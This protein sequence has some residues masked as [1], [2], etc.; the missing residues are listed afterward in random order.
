MINK[1][2]PCTKEISMTK[3]FVNGACHRIVMLGHQVHGALA[4]Q[5][6]HDMHLYIKQAKLGEISY[7]SSSYHKEVVAKEI[8]L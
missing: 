7:G 3:A 2:Q 6:E 5:L 4:F 8:G 1:G